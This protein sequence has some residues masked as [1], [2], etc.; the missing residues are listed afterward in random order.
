MACTLVRL[1][2]C[3]LR[4][5]YC[6]TPQAWSF[7]RGTEMSV[8]TIVADIEQ[9]NRP[10]VL[11]SGGEPLAQPACRDLLA[12]L[13]Q[14]GRIVQLETSGA[15]DIRDTPNGVRRIL[16]VKT[17]GS[18]EA[19]ANLEQNLE[20]LRDGDEIKFVITGQG[21]YHWARDWLHAHGLPDLGLPILFSPAWGELA[22]TTLASWMLE[23]GLPA[24]L[25]LQQHKHIWG[26]EAKGV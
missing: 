6:D 12:A 13:V 10:L 1:A 2:G 14:T 4:C 19:D 16:D 11:V 7:D 8:D 24:R 5:T 3:P 26:G 18:G 25:H 22:A 21:D 15:F 23:D 9:R 20:A 17:P